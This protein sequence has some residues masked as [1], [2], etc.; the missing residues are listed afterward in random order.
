[1]V[2]DGD[3]ALFWDQSAVDRHAEPERFD[4]LAR[5]D[6]SSRWQHEEK[7]GRRRI[8]YHEKEEEEE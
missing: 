5:L 7:E 6:R 8:Q 2:P 4:I 3:V 1:M